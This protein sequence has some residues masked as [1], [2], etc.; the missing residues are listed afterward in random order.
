[1]NGDDRRR[2]DKRLHPT[3][4]MCAS[5]AETTPPKRNPLCCEA[6]TL[7][8]SGRLRH[9]L[10]SSLTRFS[11]PLRLGRAGRGPAAAQAARLPSPLF[12]T[13]SL[14]TPPLRGR[15]GALRKPAVTSAGAQAAS[16]PWPLPLPFS[17]PLAAALAL[18]S[19]SSS[20]PSAPTLFFLKGFSRA[21]TVCAHRRQRM[22]DS[23]ASLLRALG[24]KEKQAKTKTDSDH[25]SFFAP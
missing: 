7:V 15:P 10:P 8:G 1:M 13:T 5:G 3:N 6:T 22:G 17:W 21:T 20:S 11:T 19:A 18:P 4:E 2:L 24:K 16:A 9:A 23:S 25:S 12:Q 14:P